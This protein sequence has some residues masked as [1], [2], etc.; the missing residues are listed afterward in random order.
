MTLEQ[1]R[2]IRRGKRE[3]IAALDEFTA[4]YIAAALFSTT[5][6]T[7]PDGGDPLDKNYGAED[8]TLATLAQFIADCQQFQREH[9]DKIA[10]DLSRAGADFWFTRNGHGAG[11]WD[12]DWP[13]FGDELTSAAHKFAEVNL[14]VH[15]KQIYH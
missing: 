1:T 11:F 15:R 4:S 3:L 6:E 5:D 13:E 2:P 7:R 12:G 9:F 14:Y 8:I 10:P